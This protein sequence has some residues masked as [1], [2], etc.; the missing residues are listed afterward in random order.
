MVKGFFKDLKATAA[1]LG[2]TDPA[3]LKEDKDPEFITTEPGGTGSEL[4]LLHGLFGALSNWNGVLPL[5][6]GY[7]KPIALQLPLLT[8]PRA[9]VKVKALSL[10]TE[11]FI[12][13]RAL[14]PVAICGNSLGGHVALRLTL[15]HPELVKCLVLTGTSGLYEHTVDT[16]PVRPGEPFVREHM[17]KVFFHKRCITEEGIQEIVEILKSKSNT[18][19]LISA[20]KSAK[21]DNLYDV[22]PQITCPTLLLWGEDDTVT[23]MDVAETFHK[24][25]PNS[26]LITIKG[27]GHAPMIEHPEWFAEQVR[28]FITGL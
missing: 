13:D 20:A 7:S 28:N 18:M 23:T 4:V 11:A 14:A 16:L 27:C 24:R 9:D 8:A 12:R 21:R 1:K 10:Y 17:D 22:L 19:N 3:W 25:I 5:F 6:A 2:F 15:A 26:K